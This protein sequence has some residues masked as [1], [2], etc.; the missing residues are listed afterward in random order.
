MLKSNM[1]AVRL[2]ASAFAIAG[3]FGATQAYADLDTTVAQLSPDLMSSIEGAPDTTLLSVEVHATVANMYLFRG[4]DLGNGSAMI[5]GYLV[6][7]GKGF[8][9]GI[10]VAS[11]DAELGAEYDVFFGYEGNISDVTVNTNLTNYIYPSNEEADTFGARSDFYL[12]VAYG[13][14]ALDYQDN[15]AGDS[16]YAYYAF[17]V[18]LLRYSVTLG[19]ADINDLTDSAILSNVPGDSYFAGDVRV[20]YTHLDFS[21][22]Y[23]DNLTFTVSKVLE[24][25]TIEMGGVKYE[26]N[27]DDDLLFALSYSLP[28]E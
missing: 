11:G 4:Q 25:D 22:S 9:S 17:T 2:S 7:S 3:V 6:G 8:Y 24:Q 23:N 20:D 28:I 26:N 27:V 1:M 13:P 21:Y 19:V 14:F 15:I 10:W 5:S 18:A 12:N 16:G